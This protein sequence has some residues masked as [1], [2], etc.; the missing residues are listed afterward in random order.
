MRNELK[1]FWG[2]NEIASLFLYS[3]GSRFVILEWQ[4]D[5]LIYK[6]KR[7]LLFLT[8]LRGHGLSLLGMKH[9][10]WSNEHE[11]FRAS[12]SVG[13]MLIT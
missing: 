12:N 10:D 4:Y 9:S 2:C 11:M 6:A 3:Y 5:P 1:T 8:K 13:N 7:S